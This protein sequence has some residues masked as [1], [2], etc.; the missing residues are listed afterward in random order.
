[1]LERTSVRISRPIA[2]ARAPPKIENEKQQSLTR[3]RRV[4]ID[5]STHMRRSFRR[6]LKAQAYLP[7]FCLA[8]VY[9]DRLTCT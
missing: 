5:H 1:M 7:L 4:V 6:Q 8:F 9:T 3:V 2:L